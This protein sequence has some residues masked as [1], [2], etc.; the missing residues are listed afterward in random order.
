[1]A[2]WHY[3]AMASGFTF[4]KRSLDNLNLVDPDLAAVTHRALEITRI[5]FTVIC[6]T[7]SAMEQMREFQRGT[8]RFNGVAKSEGG[9]G[10]SKHQSGRAIDF[11]SLDPDTGKSNFD[12]RLCAEVATAFYEAAA[13]LEIPIKWGGVWRS[14]KDG[15]S[16][17][18]ELRS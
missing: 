14:W 1:M 17:H 3:P 10:M 12:R 8:S 16:P 5:D 2:G 7:R 13:E 4:S 6:G 18:I 9:T 11:A 15:D